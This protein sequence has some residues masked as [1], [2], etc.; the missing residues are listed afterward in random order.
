[1]A[2]QFTWS[3][4]KMLCAPTVGSYSN[5]VIQAHWRCVGDIDGDTYSAYGTC[6]LVEPDTNFTPYEQLTQQQVLE[7]CWENGLSKKQVENAMTKN[8]DDKINPSTISPA[9]PWA[10]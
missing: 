4:E 2:A 10:S 5:V 8:H 3:V 7:W 6:N 9:L 1:M